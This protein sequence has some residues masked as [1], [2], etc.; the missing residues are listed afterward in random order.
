MSRFVAA[1]YDPFM[2]ETERACLQAW[3][4]ELLSP[5]DVPCVE[6]GAGT[7]ANLSL[8]PPGAKSITV[9]EPDAAMRARL[10]IAVAEAR[11]RDPSRSIAVLDAPA[12]RLPFGDD[13]VEAMVCTLVLCTVPDLRAA[14]R[15]MF[16]VM[17]PGARLYYIEH[18]AAWDNPARLRWQRRVEPV[19]RIVAGG[20]RVTRDTGAAIR[21]AGFEVE[22]EQRESVRKAMPWVRPSVRGVA[23]KPHR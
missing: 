23:V 6:V 14:L 9:C 17:K 3:R 22:R 19:W 4:R 18:V 21:D 20:C 5:I 12:E 10:S 16:R 11:R 13:T 8:Y 7:G 2:R 15:E 1:I